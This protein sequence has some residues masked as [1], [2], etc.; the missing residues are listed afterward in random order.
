[1]AAMFCFIN[2]AMCAVEDS[3]QLVP[4]AALKL[5][6]LLNGAWKIGEVE[7][8][9]DRAD[10]FEFTQEKDPFS[11]KVILS[12]KALTN[13]HSGYWSTPVKLEGGHK[14]LAYFRALNH[15]GILLLWM[16]GSYGN[17]KKIDERIEVR[18][19]T[20]SY[21]IPLYLSPKYTSGLN[22]SWQTLYRTFTVPAEAKELDLCFA[23][24]NFFGEGTIKFAD[25]VLVDVTGEKDLPLQADISVPNRKIKSVKINL[26]RTEGDIIFEKH[27]PAGADS[28]KEII[29]GTSAE[30]TY[31]MEITFDDSSIIRVFSPAKDQTLGL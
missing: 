19:S 24:G 21:L 15:N 28:Y 13:K 17:D 11:S 14:Y 10:N 31:R 29:P 25:I 7:Y 20:A 6:N 27:F 18:S 4:E 26:Q 3:C 23:I 8:T 16:H 9:P 1:M 5:P 30:K 22:A 2:L 12:V